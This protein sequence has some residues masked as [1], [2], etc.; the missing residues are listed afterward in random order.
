MT[1]TFKYDPDSHCLR[2]VARMEK[3]T[4]VPMVLSSLAQQQYNNHLASLRVIPCA[5]GSKWPEWELEEVVDFEI[6]PTTTYQ[7]DPMPQAFPVT[8]PRL[9]TQA[10]A[11]EIW[12]GG[13]NAAIYYSIHDEENITK[14][15]YFKTRFNVE[16]TPQTP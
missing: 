13:W 9:Y 16:L 15:Q 10:E 6:L 12:D 3:P 11:E 7:T 14:Q 4:W 1:P 5:P 8:Q 2:E